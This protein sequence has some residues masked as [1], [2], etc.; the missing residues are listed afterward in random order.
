MRS[1]R[2]C[3]V[4]KHLRG[5]GQSYRV[6]PSAPLVALPF[7]LLDLSSTLTSP[8]PL[9]RPSVSSCFQRGSRNAWQHG[10]ALIPCFN[11]R[12]TSH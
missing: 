4:L 12:R 1:P 3:I 2:A 9:S 10:L 11:A 8:N 5:H 7:P 6:W